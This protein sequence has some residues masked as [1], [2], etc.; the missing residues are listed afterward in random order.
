MTRQKEINQTSNISPMLLEE[1]V[2]LPKMR[3]ILPRHNLEPKIT[4]YVDL[5]MLIALLAKYFTF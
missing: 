3:N 4:E 1:I 2:S 5:E